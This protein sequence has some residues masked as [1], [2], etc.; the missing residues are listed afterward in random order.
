MMKRLVK[1]AIEIG[2]L[3]RPYGWLQRNKGLIL[4]YHGVTTSK[5]RQEWSHLHVDEFERQMTYL[6]NHY[7]PISLS[8][9]MD[10]L[11]AGAVGSNTAVVTFDDGYRSV[12]ELAY[13]ILK[14]LGIPTT[15][16]LISEFLSEK[17]KTPGYIWPD[18]IT[19][20]LDS[21]RDKHVD[22]SQFGLG[23]YSLDTPEK[24]Y[25]ARGQ[26]TK[27]LKLEPIAKRDEVMNFLSDKFERA[28]NHEAFATYHPMS[29]DEARTMGQDELITL[30]GHT[31][32]HP[33]L[34]RVE[35]KDLDGEIVGGKAD[36]EAKLG[37]S[38]DEFAYPN[39]RA[40]DISPASRKVAQSSFRCAVTT[41][42]GLNEPGEDPFMLKRM[43]IG[44]DLTFSRFKALLSGIYSR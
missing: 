44:S 39:G 15:V 1:S 12:Y 3:Y 5:D 16:F 30:G 29:W 32:T 24:A 43:N 10:M 4:T 19:T 14:R 40:I 18:K 42:E 35:E 6:K 20:W 25:A 41:I 34:S 17:E 36:V 21:T 8:Q 2:G 28:V 23:R 13:P 27:E 33:I 26:I 9:L 7:R 37:H 38:I 22:L 31:R 11:E